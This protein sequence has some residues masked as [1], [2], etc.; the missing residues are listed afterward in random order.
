MPCNAECWQYVC[1][2][3]QDEIINKE[4]GLRLELRLT[5]EHLAREKVSKD[6]AY[7]ERNRLVSLLSRIYPAWLARH[8]DSDI[9]W[10]DPWRWIVF[11]SLPTG[12][13][14]WHIHDSH[15]PMFS[16]LQ[17]APNIWDGHTTEEKYRRV[18]DVRGVKP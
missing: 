15:L 3:C 18:M 6:G 16:H 11:V 9:E 12:Q 17:Q 7:T 13:V 8:S 10:E 14:T 2:E 4:S 5:Q 1:G